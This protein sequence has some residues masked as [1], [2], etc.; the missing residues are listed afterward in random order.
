[1]LR[2]LWSEES[3]TDVVRDYLQSRNYAEFV[4]RDGLA[5]LVRHWERVVASVASGEAQ[6]QDDYLNDMDSRRILEEA[7]EIAPSEERVP[8]LDRVRVADD[9]IRVHLVPTS[10]CIW[11]NENAVKRGYSRGRDWWYYH[12]PERVAQDWRS[13]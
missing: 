8:W 3:V 9:R 13:F 10:V 7:L 5:G 11:G 4:V 6:H 2:A 12:R 1:L